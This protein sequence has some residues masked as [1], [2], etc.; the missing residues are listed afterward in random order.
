MVISDGPGNQ[1]EGESIQSRIAEL[2]PWF[3]NIH[4]PDGSQTSPDT[5]LGDF[6]SYKWLEFSNSIPVNLDGWTALEIGCNAG[7]YSIELAKRGAQVTGIDINPHYLTQAEW[8]SR[9]FNLENHVTLKQMQVYDL[10]HI[11]DKFDIVLFM[12]VFYHLRYPLLAMDIVAQ[13][14]QRNLIFQTAM[15]PGED[16]VNNIYDLG[17]YQRDT[18]CASGWPKMAFVEH[19]FSGDPTNWWIPNRAGVEAILRSSGMRIIERAGVE[20][21]LCEP[22]P[23]RPSCVS[24]WNSCELFAATGQRV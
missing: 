16:I 14:V 4:L 8:A 24:T 22:D 17:L 9:Q 10:A 19:M 18:L 20:T 7:F 3:Q 13:K 21:Y 11:D 12:G 23:D 6:P 15:L 2:A 1:Q 5:Y